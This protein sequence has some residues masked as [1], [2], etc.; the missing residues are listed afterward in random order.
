MFCPASLPKIIEESP[1]PALSP[2][3]RERICETAVG[4]AR[5]ANYQNAGTVEFI[6]RP[7]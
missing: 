1:S 7:R 4:I 5:A 2:E 3:L 6:F